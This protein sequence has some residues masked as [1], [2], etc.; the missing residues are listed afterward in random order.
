[1]STLSCFMELKCDGFGTTV[2][3]GTST[4]GEVLVDFP[5]ILAFFCSV[6]MRRKGWILQMTTGRLSLPHP[7]RVP[8][9][10]EPDASHAGGQWFKS[11]AAHQA[12][13]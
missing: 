1:M 2:A 3:F 10:I 6:V 8:H 13:T 5:T 12:Q 7:S 4:P 9:R 11:T